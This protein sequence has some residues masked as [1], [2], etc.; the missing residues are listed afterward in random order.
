[1]AI[2]GLQHLDR[3]EREVI[4]QRRAGARILGDHFVLELELA[5][6]ADAVLRAEPDKDVLG[7]DR[8]HD[9]IGMG[10]SARD[11]ERCDGFQKSHVT[12]PPPVMPATCW[13][14]AA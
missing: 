7:V 5:T 12:P 3:A 10:D 2:A 6:R 9:R 8:E 14:R 1:N 4:A 13:S 11:R